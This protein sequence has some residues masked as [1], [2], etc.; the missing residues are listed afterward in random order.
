MNT[1]NYQNKDKLNATYV[2]LYY[3]EVSEEGK[4]KC[5][6]KNSLLHYCKLEAQLL[7]NH[8][9]RYEL[10]NDKLVNPKLLLNLPATP[11]RHNGGRVLVGPDNNIYL[12]I[13]DI[14]HTTQAQNFI[15]SSE[16]DG[17]GGILR[18]TQE[19]RKVGEGILGGKDPII[20]YYA[21]GIRNSFG[22]DFDPL[23]GNLWDTE[24]GPG[25]ADEINLVR[26][27]F[28]SGWSKVQG[29]WDSH[30]PDPLSRDSYWKLR[31]NSTQNVTRDDIKGLVDF[32]GK[33]KYSAPELTW[34]FSVGPTAIKFMNSDKLGKKYE[35]DIFVADFRNGIIYH[36]DLTRDRRNLDLTGPLSDKIA[37]SWDDLQ[38]V[39]WGQGFG[40]ITDLEVGPDGYL[41]VV[42]LSEGGYDCRRIHRDCITYDSPVGGSIFRIAPSKE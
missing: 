25:H 5:P 31:D 13:G 6:T 29:V 15:N 4:E 3:T 33:G 14:G 23:T 7:G 27:G 2:F 32:N 36:F 12:V 1:L 22:L 8:L 37:N 42:A 10:R 19:G 40:A 20:K 28:N 26:P 21:Y 9:Y 35:N 17:T 30:Q 11:N 16:P 24:N 38:N 18:I 39:I 34:A 41:Y